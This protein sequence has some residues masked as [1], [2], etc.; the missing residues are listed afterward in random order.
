MVRRQSLRLRLS[1]QLDRPVSKFDGEL[2]VLAAV[3]LAD[4]LGLLLH[5]GGEGIEVA[6]DIFSRLF[7]A[8]GYRVS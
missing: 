3:L 2:H 4:F 8:S 5:E 1:L 6:G 7:L